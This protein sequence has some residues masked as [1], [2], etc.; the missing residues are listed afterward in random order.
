MARLLVIGFG[1][2]LRGDDAFGF[3]AA[4]QFSGRVAGSGVEVLALHQLAPELMEQVSQAGS[5]VFIDASLEGPPGELRRTAVTPAE[6]AS[7]EAFTHH[8]TPQALLAG[9]KAVY[10]R[11]PEAVLYTVGAATFEFGAAMSSE[12][13]HAL[14]RLVAE[15]GNI[16][17][18]H[19][20]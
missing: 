9:T 12:V 15:L 4:E 8:L 1:N 19:G 18:N 7:P 13:A 16:V 3:A 2:P 17:S 10:G 20:V 6:S 14:D 11:A 5:V